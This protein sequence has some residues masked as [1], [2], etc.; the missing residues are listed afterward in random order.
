MVDSSD[1]SSRGE[2]LYRR[3]T[4]L[5]M[6]LVTGLVCVYDTVL[7]ICFASTLPYEEL[8][9]LCNLIIENGGVRQLI[10]IKSIGTIIG[11]SILIGLTYTRF[12]VCVVIIFFLALFLFFYLTFYCPSGDY[13]VSSFMREVANPID[14]FINF[15]FTS[16]FNDV[17]DSLT[18]GNL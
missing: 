7:S 5:L 14:R 1:R 3:L 13:R 11:I 16:D 9:P 2:S 15:Y 4:Y 10:I 12:K 18:E 17:V 6:V 8:N